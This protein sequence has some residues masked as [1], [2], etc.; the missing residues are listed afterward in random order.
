MLCSRQGRNQR[1]R[2]SVS[3]NV[4]RAGAELED[5]LQD[6]DGGSQLRALVN[7]P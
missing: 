4:E 2:M 1:Q 7:G 6:L 3:L 5:A